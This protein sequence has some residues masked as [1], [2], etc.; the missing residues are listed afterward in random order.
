MIVKIQP[1]Q[2]VKTVTEIEVVFENFELMAKEGACRVYLMSNQQV[3]DVRLVTIPPD[4][5]ASW[6]TDDAVIISY[7]VSALNLVAI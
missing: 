4:I 2:V 6:G 3:V 1:I 5:Y 7:V